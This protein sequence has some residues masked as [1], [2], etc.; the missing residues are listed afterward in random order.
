MPTP[1]TPWG[2]PFRAV[3]ATVF[4]EF[5]IVSGA[6][7]LVTGGLSLATMFFL[8]HF[9]PELRMLIHSIRNRRG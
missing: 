5:V 1:R 2:H 4:C 6:N 7:F 3:K 8:F 9:G